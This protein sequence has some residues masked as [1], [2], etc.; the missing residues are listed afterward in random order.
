MSNLGGIRQSQ[1][2]LHTW[3]GLVVGWVL[4]LIFIAG[5]AEE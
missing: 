3:S 2:V 1:S 5:T 4:F